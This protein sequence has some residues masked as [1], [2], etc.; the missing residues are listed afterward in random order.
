MAA[1]FFIVGIGFALCYNKKNAKDG[2]RLSHND[3]MNLVCPTCGQNLT[4]P[5]H[6]EEFSCLYC[7]ARLTKGDFAPPVPSSE[8]QAGREYYE[9]HILDAITGYLGI[10]KEVTNAQYTAAFARYRDGNAETFRQLDLAVSTG[11]LSLDEAVNC[12]L[13]RLEAHWDNN[14]RK[15][16]RNYMIDTDKFVIAVF[17]V[18]MVRELKLGC[19]EGYCEAL[20]KSWCLRHPK[21]PFYLGT[22]AE[23]T[24]GFEKKLLGLCFITTAICE[25]EGKDDNCEELTAFRQFRD[26]FL[27]ACPDGDQ[28]IEEYY[29]K[30]PG[31]LLH[32]DLARDRAMIYQKLRDNY[33]QPCYEDILAGRL[34][35][36]K[37]RYVRMVRD[38]ERKYLS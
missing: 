3:V 37:E 28:L 18:P 35:Q 20:Q 24:K 22:Y 34:P 16:R 25:F 9:A 33:L 38:L 13:D 6:L 30:A 19:S 17:L 23:M 11:S 27:R 29:D 15:Q 7:G 14:Q 12:F 1:K 36:C 8:G 21:S 5:S 32:I 26:G 31:I 4:I 10:D 2:D